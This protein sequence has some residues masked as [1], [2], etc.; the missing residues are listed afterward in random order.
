MLSVRNVRKYFGGIKA[1]DGVSLD[2]TPRSITGLIGPNGAGKTTLFNIISGYY[3]P[4]AG[5]IYFKGERIDGLSLH[6]TFKKGL[7]RTFQISRELKLM[8]V[9]ENV[10]LPPPHQLGENLLNT[11]FLP[12]K[13]RKQEQELREKALEILDSVGLLH[14]KD[15]YAGN[16]SGGQKRLLEL[17]R[18]MMADPE[19]VLLDEIAAG[20]SP[21]ERVML[22]EHIRRLVEERGITVLVVGHEMDFVMDLCDPVIVMDKG[23]KL[24]EGSPE[25]VSKDPRVLEVYL[26][27][28]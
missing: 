21:S 9:L 11:W 26:G 10:M 2:V 23:K 17:A 3:K 25:E 27:G 22:A 8:T 18:V 16:L 20:V 7:C 6:E 14:L 13:V 5:E 24:T 28:G 19:M 1:V 15:E 4:D 12:S